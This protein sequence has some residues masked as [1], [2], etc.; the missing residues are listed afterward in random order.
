[1]KTITSTSRTADI[2]SGCTTGLLRLFTAL[3]LYLTFGLLADQAHCLGKIIG[4]KQ[5][6]TF[7][8]LAEACHGILHM[9]KMV[10]DDFGDFIGPR[11]KCQPWLRFHKAGCLQLMRQA[12]QAGSV[13]CRCRRNGGLVPLQKKIPCTQASIPRGAH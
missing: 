11:F 13:A 10:A 1:M 3:V 6:L 7:A 5:R 12:T 2:V 8:S 4:A 9:R